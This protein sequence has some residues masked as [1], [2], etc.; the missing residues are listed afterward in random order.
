MAKNIKKYDKEIEATEKKLANLKKEKRV[1]EEKLFLEI[2][3]KLTQ[4]K[5]LETK[6]KSLDEILEELKLELDLAKEEVKRPAD[7]S[8]FSAEIQSE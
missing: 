7:I 8:S 1:A 5:R 2:G 6:D 3:K 4:L